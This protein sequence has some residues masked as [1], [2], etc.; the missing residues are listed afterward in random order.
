MWEKDS[1]SDLDIEKSKSKG[2][3]EDVYK[4][5]SAEN[6]YNIIEDHGSKLSNMKSSAFYKQFEK[7][8]DKWETNLAVVSETIELLLSV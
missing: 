3:N 4:I 8:I 2:N 6:I 1:K 7:K 5:R